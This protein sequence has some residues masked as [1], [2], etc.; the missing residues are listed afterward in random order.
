MNFTA[1]DV[2]QLREQTGCGMM[3]C[4]KALVECDGDMAKATDYL[5][6]KGL[7]NAAKKA[8]RIAAEGLVA[9]IA[10]ETAGVVVEVNSETDFV[11]GGD[12]FKDLCNAIAQIALDQNPADVDALL[13]CSANGKTVEEMVQD[14]FLV[15]RE[16]MKV[17]RFARLDGYV[18]NY[19]HAGGKI[20]VIAKFE[21]TAE[22]AATAEFKAMG[23]DICMQIA[24]V[25]PGYLDKAS[26][27]ADALDHEKAILVAQMK[28][29]PKM[30]SKPDAVLEKIVAGKMGK[31]YEE[32]C[33]VEQKFVK[34]GAMTVLEYIN[35]VAKQLGGEIKVVDF[36]RYEKG[37]GI[38]KREDDFAAEVASMVK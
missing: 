33:L 23:K 2:Q 26:V 34:D 3:D 28:E 5:R 1:K 27:P 11:A 29:D 35:S 8:S 12:G 22:I 30:A 18:A 37:E 25:N 32:N 31:F 17:R 9:A 13:K 14:Y 19:V 38:Q 36:V 21:T 24:A 7:A 16:N 4:K 10:G 6:E 15:V 20:G